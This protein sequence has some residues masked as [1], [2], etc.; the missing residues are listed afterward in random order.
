MN[1]GKSIMS[2]D[3]NMGRCVE[4]GGGAA[5]FNLEKICRRGLRD[6]LSPGIH[7]AQ[8]S[9]RPVLR[10]DVRVELHG[11]KS[12]VSFEVIPVRLP[13][14]ESRYFLILFGQPSVQRSELHRAGLLVRFYASLFGA[15]TAQETEKDNQISSLRR[16]LD[17]TRNYLQ[18]SAEEQE[19]VTEE[20]KSAHEEALPANEEFLSTNEEL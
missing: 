9:E 1:E 16:E 2:Y 14:T 15:G 12:E 19:A 11:E 20:M 7:E 6:E 3:A 8:K 10:E 13:G 4:N 5:S 18:A 17:A